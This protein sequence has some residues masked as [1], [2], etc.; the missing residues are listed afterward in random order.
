LSVFFKIAEIVFATRGVV[1]FYS[2]G[3][4]TH[5]CMYVGL[6]PRLHKWPTWMF[7]PILPKVA[8]IGLQIFEI[9]N[10]CNVHLLHIFNFFTNIF[11][12]TVFLQSFWVKCLD[13]Y[14]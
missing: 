4:V 6:A 9:L 11:V 12:T 3:V 1:N 2:A 14:L 8:N 7:M 13:W 5:D 10:I